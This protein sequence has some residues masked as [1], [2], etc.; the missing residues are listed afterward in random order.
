MHVCISVCP[1]MYKCSQRPKEVI[2]SLGSKDK[3]CCES[4][5]LGAGD[6]LGPLKKAAGSIS[7][8]ASL[9]FP[10]SGFFCR[11]ENG[12]QSLRRARLGKCSFCSKWYCLKRFWNIY[13]G[14][15][16]SHLI[17]IFINS[18][19]MWLKVYIS[20]CSKFY[21]LLHDWGGVSSPT[22][23]GRMAGSLSIDHHPELQ[24]YP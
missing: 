9:Q 7:C 4:L 1:H 2:A 13:K 8:G 18:V 15:H 19:L 22:H 24:E 6:L 20:W 17:D 16:T 23:A 21:P 11:V 10:C 14:S 12:S 3:S 5:V